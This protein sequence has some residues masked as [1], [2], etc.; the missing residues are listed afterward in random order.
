MFDFLMKDKQKKT[1]KGFKL[2]MR[3]YFRRLTITIIQVTIYIIF[4]THLC[5]ST[6]TVKLSVFGC[7]LT[8]QIICV[9]EIL[10]NALQQLN[11]FKDF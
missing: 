3:V 8:D 5:S 7:G 9:L 6:I 2:L 4:R 11:L 10:I 1:N